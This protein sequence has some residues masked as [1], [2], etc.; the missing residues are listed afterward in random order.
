MIDSDYT[1][2]IRFSR[3]DMPELT[4][5]PQFDPQAEAEREAEQHRKEENIRWLEDH[6]GFRP[7]GAEW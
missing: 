4:D 5:T 7:L 2:P 6:C 3:D 1:P